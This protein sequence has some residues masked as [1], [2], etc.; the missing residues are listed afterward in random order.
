MAHRLLF[1]LIVAILVTIAVGAFSQKGQWL[2]PLGLGLAAWL[3][4]GS[5]AEIVQRGAFSK[6]PL[7]TALRRLLGL[8]RSVWSTAF[9]HFGVGVTLFGIVC[10][11]AY[12]TETITVLKPQQTIQVGQFTLRHEGFLTTSGPNYSERS[13]QLSIIRN[14]EVVDIAR[15]SKR[16]FP[17]RQ[18]PTSEA[19]IHTFGFSQLYLALGDVE[20]EG[21]VT[22]RIWWKP[23]ITLI[24]LGAVVMVLA[25]GFSLSDRRLRIGAPK[26][27][28][29][30]K[31]NL[32]PSKDAGSATHA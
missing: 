1:A 8:P 17:A 27:S 23:Y 13:A 11:T 7:K 26:R 30:S 10:V 31:A 29:R 6:V 32:A 14:G 16:F 25:G 22:L 3:M 18:M 20:A 24:W 12:E 21:N 15:P 4:I 28:R 9:A 5:F 2:A 19:S